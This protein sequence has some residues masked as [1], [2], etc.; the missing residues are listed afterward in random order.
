M[1]DCASDMLPQMT[2][3]FPEPCRSF[4]TSLAA[5][6][7]TI[8]AAGY[9]PQ[10]ARPSVLDNTTFGI[11]FSLSAKR[12]S[13]PGGTLGQW[14]ANISYVTRPSKIVSIESRNSI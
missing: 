14:P 6:V 4:A 9:D 8:F 13:G 7:L 12:L 1:S 11:A 5:L 3:S 10:G 2:I